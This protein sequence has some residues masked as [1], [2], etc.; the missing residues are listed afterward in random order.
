MD[1]ILI[2]RF[3]YNLWFLSPRC[4]FLYTLY[5]ICYKT[6]FVINV[7]TDVSTF[8]ESSNR[9]RTPPASLCLVSARSS[10]SSLTTTIFMSWTWGQKPSWAAGHCQPTANPNA[11]LVSYQVSPLGSMDWMARTTQAWC[12]PPVCPIIAFIWFCGKRM[13]R[14]LEV[15]TKPCILKA[16]GTRQNEKRVLSI[17]KKTSKP[18]KLDNAWTKVFSSS[19]LL[20]PFALRLMLHSFLVTCRLHIQRLFTLLFNDFKRRC[21]GFVEQTIA[22]TMMWTIR[23]FCS[24]DLK[25]SCLWVQGLALFEN[26]ITRVIA[27][28]QARS[29]ELAIFYSTITRIDNEVHFVWVLNFQLICIYRSNILNTRN[30][31]LKLFFSLKKLILL[32][33]AVVLACALKERL[34]VSFEKTDENARRFNQ[35]G[36]VWKSFR[37]GWLLLLTLFIFHSVYWSCAFLF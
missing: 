7:H 18:T 14:H 12:L 22:S 31:A 2:I 19:L 35:M 27:A 28:Q 24:A 25:E 5:N 4:I 15:N 10:L 34:W 1:R 26:R 17:K 32:T 36:F 37:G 3:T 9:N 23:S 13:G 29:V 33:S 16:G 30:V 6:P 11:A 8:T 21:R 20:L